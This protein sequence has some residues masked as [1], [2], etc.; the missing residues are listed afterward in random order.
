MPCPHGR[1]ESRPVSSSWGR[2][3]DDLSSSSKAPPPSTFCLVSNIIIL[4][5]TNSNHRKK[6]EDS[7]HWCFARPQ[8]VAFKLLKEL[9]TMQAL[10]ALPYIRDFPKSAE[11]VFGPMPLKQEL[12]PSHVSLFPGFTMKEVLDKFEESKRMMDERDLYVGF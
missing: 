8:R 11:Q 3:T 5:G 6:L 1:V 10:S 7:Y 2:D 9:G 12:Q 4:E